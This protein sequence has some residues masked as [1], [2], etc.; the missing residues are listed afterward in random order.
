MANPAPQMPLRGTQNAPKF[1]GKTLALL[2]CFLEDVDILGTAAGITDL[3]K[4]RATIRYADLEEAEGWELLDEVT[5]NPPDWANFARAVK[6]LY[7]GCKGANRYCRADI[8]Y[9]VQEFR[10]KPMRTLEDLGEYQ[11][12]FLKIAHILINS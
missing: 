5:A 10:V 12:K 7:P 1:D 3:E 9:L 11:H 4:I 2:P 8:Q 6:K